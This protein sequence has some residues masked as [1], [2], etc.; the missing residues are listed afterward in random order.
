MKKIAIIGDSDT[1]HAQEI[2][3]QLAEEKEHGITIVDFDNED[4][5]QRLE[6]EKM[7]LMKMQFTPPPTR[8]ERRKEA[9]KQKKRKK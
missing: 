9:R 5:K 3:K 2:A 1:L 4:V 6:I 7:N 8:A